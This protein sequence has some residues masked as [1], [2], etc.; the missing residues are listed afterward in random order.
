MHC[1]SYHTITCIGRKLQYKRDV[2]RCVIATLRTIWRKRHW[3]LPGS[4][5]IVQQMEIR[6]TLFS[7]IYIDCAICIALYF[8]VVRTDWRRKTNYQ[9]MYC[10]SIVYVYTRISFYSVQRIY[11]LNLCDNFICGTLSYQFL[12]PNYT[13]KNWEKITF[14][15]RI[16][17]KWYDFFFI[18]RVS[19]SFWIYIILR[20]EIDLILSRRFCYLWV[21][22]VR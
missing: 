14:F 7:R 4:V 3:W 15:A 1:I 18:T 22:L 11:G 2:W 8:V 12:F 9:W 13:R 6:V 5:Q 10:T 16:L 20:R 17:G 21:K 19:R